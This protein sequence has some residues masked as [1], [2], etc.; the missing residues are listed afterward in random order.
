MVL[1]IRGY[2]SLLTALLVKSFNDGIASADVIVE[3]V[4]I[5]VSFSVS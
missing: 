3:I 5:D 1:K 4:Y 2:S